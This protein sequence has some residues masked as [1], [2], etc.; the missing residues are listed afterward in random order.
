MPHEEDTED[1]AVEA[2]DDSGYNHHHSA[3]WNKVV[4]KKAEELD[5]L[6]KDQ[7]R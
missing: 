7:E 2:G 6:M 5:N 4:D 1:L 3:L